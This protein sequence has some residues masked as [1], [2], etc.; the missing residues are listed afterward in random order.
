MGDAWRKEPG[1]DARHL[2]QRQSPPH[3]P[4]PVSL[5]TSPAPAIS[6]VVGCREEGSAVTDETSRTSRD[7][8][9]KRWLRFARPK[10]LPFRAHCVVQMPM[11][12]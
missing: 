5:T 10:S 11:L 7:M 1:L 12:V 6:E 4:P 8:L 2:G 9:S 3:P